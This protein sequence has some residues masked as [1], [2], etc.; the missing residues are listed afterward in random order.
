MADYRI[1]NHKPGIKTIKERLVINEAISSVPAKVRQ[2][3]ENG[4]IIDVG[5]DGGSQYDY[6][7]DIMYIAKGADKKEVIHEIGHLVENKMLDE[8]K[9]AEIRKRFVGSPT[10]KGIKKDIYYDAGNNPM[11]IYLL[12]NENFISEYQGRIYVD[13]ALEAFDTEGNFKDELLWEFISESFREYVEDS[14]GLKEKSREL[15]NLI[16]EAVE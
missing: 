7:H 14:E 2:A 10:T 4:T 15:Y 12:D 3:L 11:E 5:K 6:A 1:R 13:T 16:R 9:V 8:G